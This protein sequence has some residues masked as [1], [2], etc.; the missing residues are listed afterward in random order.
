MTAAI[1]LS[2]SDIPLATAP[3]EFR[4]LRRD[5][6]RML[7]AEPGKPLRHRKA[8]DLHHE[9]A[10]GD[11][12][13]LNTSDTIPAAVTGVTEAGERVEVHLSTPLPSTGLSPATAL[14]ATES[15]WIVEIRTPLPV[16]SRQSTVDRTAATIRLRGGVAEIAVDRP[17][18]SGQQRLYAATVRTPAPLLRWLTEHGEPIRYDYVSARWPISAYRT[19]HGD[20][21]GSVEMP[22]AGR[23]IT[24]G[25]LRHLRAIGVQIATVVL[26]CGVSSQESGEP[27]YAEWF[28][29]PR[30]TVDAIDTAHASGHRVLAIGTTVVRAL[31]SAVTDG[32]LAAKTGWTEHVVTPASGVSTVDGILTGWHE[33]EASHLQMLAAISG[34]RLLS[35]SYEEAIAAGYRWHE[36]GDVHLLWKP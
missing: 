11:V 33:P 8:R 23:P 22:S 5:A 13:V 24:A 35:E 34:P 27:P 10:A 16:G 1:R 28:S 19:E 17:Y 12:V 36:F 21:P 25:M 6:V 26:H 20:T 30:S 3:A 29:V 18:P 2:T 32:R 31:E 14:A 15:Q 9:L 7:V 4:G